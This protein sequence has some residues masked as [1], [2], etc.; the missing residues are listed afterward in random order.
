MMHP[1]HFDMIR[2]MVLAGLTAVIGGNL[3][4]TG[5]HLWHLAAISP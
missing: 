1:D 4:K 5:V 3:A 2:I